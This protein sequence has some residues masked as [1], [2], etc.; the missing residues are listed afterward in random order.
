MKRYL[1][2]LLILSYQNSFSQNVRNKLIDTSRIYIKFI[3]TQ[4]KSTMTTVYVSGGMNVFSQN[5][6]IP[7][8]TFMW[9]RCDSIKPSFVN[10]DY[11]YPDRKPLLVTGQFHSGDSLVV[12]MDSRTTK[13]INQRR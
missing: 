9:F 8:S 7:N 4:Y 12:D 2:V 5:L 13:V 1:V 6:N 10:V 11:T 3:S